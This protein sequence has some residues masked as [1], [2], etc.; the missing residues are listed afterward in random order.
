MDSSTAFIIAALIVTGSLINSS[1]GRRNYECQPCMSMQEC[2]EEPNDFCP[3]GE[4]RDMCG[5]RT[6][7]KGPADRCGGP[8]GIYGRCAEGLR[9]R[10]DERCHGCADKGNSE[11]ECY[12]KF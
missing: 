3:F 9:C 12:P 6:C 5:R 1:F 11:F 2:N 7:A 10:S 8:N 4:T